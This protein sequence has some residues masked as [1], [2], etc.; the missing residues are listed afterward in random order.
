MDNKKNVHVHHLSATS[1]F[2]F[3]FLLA[4]LYSSRD[5]SAIVTYR[6]RSKS[7]GYIYLKTKGYLEFNRN[8]STCESFIC[9]NTLLG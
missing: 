9:V 7:N 3:S 6:L 2:D 4:V 1:T 8:S 5:G